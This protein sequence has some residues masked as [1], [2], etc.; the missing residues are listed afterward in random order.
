[1]QIACVGHKEEES[2][3]EHRVARD[4]DDR[5]Y[6][7][8]IVQYEAEAK[9]WLIVFDDGDNDFYDYIEL[10]VANQLIEDNANNNGVDAIDVDNTG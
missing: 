9:K 7:G 4:I 2:L 6:F 8:K 10:C 1:M 5:L 3:V